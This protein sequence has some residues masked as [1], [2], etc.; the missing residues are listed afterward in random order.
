MWWRKKRSFDDFKEEIE[1]H[2]AIEADELGGELAAISTLPPGERSVTSWLPRKSG[3][4]TIIGCSSI[5]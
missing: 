2:L 4:N 1:S 3:T 5:S